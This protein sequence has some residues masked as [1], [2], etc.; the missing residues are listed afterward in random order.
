MVPPG[1]ARKLALQ[2]S[3]EEP[4]Q[5][6]VPHAEGY[7]DGSEYSHSERE[8]YQPW[9]VWYFGEGR[10]DATDPLGVISAVRRTHFTKA[11]NA[12]R[13]LKALDP[14]QGKWADPTGRV[15]ARSEAWGCNRTHE[16]EESIEA[17]RLIC[18]SDFLKN[19]LVKRRAELL[20]L[21]ILRRYDK[22]F[23]GRGSQ[24]WHTTAVVRID[25]SLDFE[26]YPGAM[27]KLHVMKY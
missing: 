18:S 21:I 13:S 15:A 2:L 10:L 11:I 22:G 25:H 24:Y 4:F 1:H 8:P 19:V 26:L 17:E 23:D 14:F 7:D 3:Q 12:I 20:V 5:A 6:W 27:N 16:E 9:I